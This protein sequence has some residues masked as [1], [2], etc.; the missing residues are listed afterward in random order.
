MDAKDE[1]IFGALLY[2]LESF[3]VDAHKK[4]EKSVSIKERKV[5]FWGMS[6]VESL[7]TQIVSG[8]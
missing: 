4:A 6:D 2:K 7:M 1:K 5:I 3:L 8:N